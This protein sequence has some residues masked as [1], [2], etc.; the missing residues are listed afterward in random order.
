MGIDKSDIRN[1]V[2]WDLSSTVEEYSQQIGRA[3]RD[4]K[5]SHCM[6][7]L[8]PNSFHVRESFARGDLPSRHSLRQLLGDIFVT[9][10]N[11]APGD[12]LTTN[13]YNQSKSFDIRPSPLSIMYATLELR[14]GLMRAIT[15]EYTNYSFEAMPGYYA[16]LKND[17]TAVGKAIWSEATKKSKYHHIDLSAASKK[18]GLNRMD[19]VKKLTFL[20]NNGHIKLKV[21]GVVNR[22]RV[23]KPLPHTEAELDRLADSL[24]ADLASRERDALRRANEVM[25]LVT[26]KKCF[27]LAL[28][29]H[30]G[31]CL[32]D[33]KARCGHCT[34]C[35][36]GTPVKAPSPPLKPTTPQSIQPILQATD[37]RDD[38]RFLARVAFGIKSPRVTALKLDRSPVFRSLADHDFDVSFPSLPGTTLMDSTQGANDVI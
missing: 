7:Y 5:T 29:E 13:Q 3:G 9:D 25:E 26:G 11:I 4:G 6:Y 31:M 15:P 8:G 12:V 10:T 21:S 1:I 28:T 35:I 27:A 32:P 16:I 22:Y 34:Y 24:Y 2:H 37:V 30:F 14:Y 23:L 36:T 20:D 18:L 33:D 17:K 19:L 38:P